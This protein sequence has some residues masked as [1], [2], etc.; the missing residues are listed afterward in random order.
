MYS[1][2]YSYLENVAQGN[3][4][5]YTTITNTFQSVRMNEGDKYLL[6][7]YSNNSI[8]YKIMLFVV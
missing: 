5:D 4:G 6:C 7:M 3:V 8:D 1:N 2:K